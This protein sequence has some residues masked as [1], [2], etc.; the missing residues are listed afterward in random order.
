MFVMFFQTPFEFLFPFLVWTYNNYEVTFLSDIKQR[1]AFSDV[2]IFAQ[3]FFHT[4]YLTPMCSCDNHL[5]NTIVL[6]RYV[7][8][9]PTCSC[10]NRLPNTVVLLRHVCLTPMCSCG[11]HLPNTMVLLPHSKKFPCSN[12]NYSILD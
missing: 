8:R 6:L 12:F 7:C 4:I 11:N 10:G 5:P 9:T 2:Q 1:P 3:V